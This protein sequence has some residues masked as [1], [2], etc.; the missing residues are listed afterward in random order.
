MKEIKEI[1][2]D[3]DSG[4]TISNYQPLLDSFDYEIL[5]QVDDE[6]YQGDSRLLLYDEGRYGL[7]IFG[8]GSCSGCDALQAC[9]S[10]EEVDELRH[11]ILNDIQWESDSKKMKSWIE[12][13]D[14]ELEYSW[15]DKETEEFVDLCL[16]YLNEAV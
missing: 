15:Y 4:D 11:F 5:I 3:Y 12:N 9:D 8:W 16:L 14:W 1:Y 6:D 7:L 10:F 2:P 13:K